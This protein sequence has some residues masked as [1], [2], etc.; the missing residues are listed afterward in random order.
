MSLF[1]TDSD[2]YAYTYQIGQ[3]VT[4]L[5]YPLVLEPAA[6]GTCSKSLV[7]TVNGDST[8]LMDTYGIIATLSINNDNSEAVVSLTSLYY[9]SNLDGQTLNIDIIVTINDIEL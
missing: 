1:N 8:N 5:Q 2:T 3:Y 7:F 9:D 4:P 6:T